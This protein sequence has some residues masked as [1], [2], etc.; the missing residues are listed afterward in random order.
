[1]SVLPKI[2][3][4]IIHS[5]LIQNSNP[6]PSQNQSISII[7]ETIAFEVL[8]KHRDPGTC[9][10]CDIDNVLGK[11]PK[12]LG[13]H[14]WF[15]WRSNYAKEV[16]EPFETALNE[17]T[18]LQLM[19]DLEPVESKTAEII[20]RLQQENFPAIA[21]T[22]RGMRLGQRTIKQLNAIG[23]DFSNNGF[24]EEEILWAHDD[25]RKA[26]EHVMFEK[27]ILFTSGQNKGLC[28]K[29]FM[30]ETG[31]IPERVVYIDDDRKHIDHVAEQC[32][33]LGIDFFGYHYRYLD[34]W[35]EQFDK[36]AA[37]E[38]LK[39]LRTWIEKTDAPSAED[40]REIA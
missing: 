19:I 20:K 38:Q 34:P 8:L 30:E 22:S 5:R 40:K 29:I 14:Q 11:T 10:F 35:V 3:S 12:Q 27:G 2:E 18:A 25:R 32:K 4:A 24:R 39:F 1:M 6:L 7:T 33:I 26:S 15:V 28:L 23:I 13:S 36:K 37:E 16:N 21:L 9:F 17:W 31:K